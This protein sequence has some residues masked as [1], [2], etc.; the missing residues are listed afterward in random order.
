MPEI[1]DHV[2]VLQAQSRVDFA[3]GHGLAA[4]RQFPICP[5]QFSDAFAVA[6][7]VSG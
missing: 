4:V 6:A 3:A 2:I 7:E 5:A 1:V